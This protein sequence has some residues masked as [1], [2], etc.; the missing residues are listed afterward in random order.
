MPLLAVVRSLSAQN[1]L[2]PVL[3]GLKRHSARVRGIGILTTDLRFLGCRIVGRDSLPRGQGIVTRRPLVFQL[4]GTPVP[5]SPPDPFSSDTPR[6]PDGTIHPRRKIA[7]RFQRDS[8]GGQ[9]RGFQGGRSEH[10]NR[11]APD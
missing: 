10:E 11:Q 7:H 6:T 3:V 1:L 9:A 4:V 2:N 8:E 5:S